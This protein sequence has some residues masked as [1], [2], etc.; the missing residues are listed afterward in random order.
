MSRYAMNWSS[1]DQLQ[2]SQIHPLNFPT[3]Q[4]EKYDLQIFLTTQKKTPD[5][6]LSRSVSIM[7]GV[8]CAVMTSLTGLMLL[9]FVANLKDSAPIVI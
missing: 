7:P 1:Y 9:S 6:E 4:L 3:A 5:K 8:M 2:N